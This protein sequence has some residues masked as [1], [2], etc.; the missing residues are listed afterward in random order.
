MV[1]LASISI[2]GRALQ[3]HQNWVKDKKGTVNVSWEN[4]VQALEDRFGDHSKGDPMAELLNLK[5][6]GTIFITMISLSICWEGWIYLKSM[7]SVSFLV[8]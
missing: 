6:S 7:P 5:Q 2:E 4:Y 8:D 3:W 1:K